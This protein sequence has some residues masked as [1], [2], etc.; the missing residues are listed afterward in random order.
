MGRGAWWATVHRV[1]DSQTQLSTP[2][3]IPHAPELLSPHAAAA[4]ALEPMCH[5]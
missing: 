5:T 1:A 2:R 4:E 3:K